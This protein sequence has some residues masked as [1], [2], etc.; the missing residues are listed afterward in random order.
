LKIAGG[1]NPLLSFIVMGVRI[2]LQMQGLRTLL[3]AVLLVAAWLSGCGKSARATF[4]A[5]P[6]P[7]T[8]T[9]GSK[10]GKTKLTWN[11]AAT[12]TVEIHVGKPDGPI[13]CKGSSTGSCETLKWVTDG[14]TFYLQDS[15]RRPTD[16]SATLSTLS[17][18]VK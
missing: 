1:G 12:N 5:D 17:V 9:N 7:V 15:S 14:M 16:P 13:L 3:T 10:L 2:Y 4:A 8:V 18:H 11:T 6:N